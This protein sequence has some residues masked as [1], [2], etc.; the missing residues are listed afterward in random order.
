MVLQS[1]G[2]ISI[3]DV[4][5]EFGPTLGYSNSLAYYRTHVLGRPSGIVSLSEFY[6][7]SAAI[8]VTPP[9]SRSFTHPAYP[10]GGGEGYSGY[11]NVPR[12]GRHHY[13]FVAAHFEGSAEM[14]FTYYPGFMQL[15]DEEAWATFVKMELPGVSSTPYVAL[16]SAFTY[17]SGDPVGSWKH[18]LPYD[19]TSPI[20]AP[21]NTGVLYYDEYVP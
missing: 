10:G 14:G 4:K 13:F 17:T 3:G 12:R 11:V 20:S 2:P 9:V 21:A 6:G 1:S 5:A 19:G 8:P 15:F 16:K 7:R 18:I